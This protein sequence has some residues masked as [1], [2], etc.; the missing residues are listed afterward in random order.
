MLYAIF[1]VSHSRIVNV[2]LIN[3]SGTVYS[4]LKNQN[5]LSLRRR[6]RHEMRIFAKPNMKFNSI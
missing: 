1:V 4:F 5:Y 3:S 2:V 6:R